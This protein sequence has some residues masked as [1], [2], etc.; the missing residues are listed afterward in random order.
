[1]AEQNQQKSNQNQMTFENF[2]K[3]NLKSYG[4]DLFQVMEKGLSSSVKEMGEKRG[5]TISL[6]A[7]FGNGKT[8]FLKMFEHFIK[9]EKQNYDIILINAWESDF[10][11]EPVITILSELAIWIEQTKS[12][13]VNKQKEPKIKKAISGI[14]SAIGSVFS[15]A[16][17]HKTGVNIKEVKKAYSK[18][19]SASP[20]QDALGENIL[21]D[22]KQ[23]KKAVQK[24]REAILEYIKVSQKK[25][26]IIVDELDRTRPDYAVR[27]LEDIKHFFDIENVVFLVAVNRTQ[28]EVTVKCLYGQDLDFEGYYR[29]FFKQEMELPD[30]YKEA[31]KLVS[32]LIEKTNV[33]YRDN[34]DSRVK[35]TYWS[36]KMFNLTLREIESFIRIFEMVLGH[37]KSIIEWIYMDA[38]SFFICLYLK[39]KEVFKSIK[40][41][42]SVDNFISFIKNDSSLKAFL[43]NK[44]KYYN[45]NRLLGI[46]ACSFLMAKDRQHFLS[47]TQ[48]NR[49]AFKKDKQTIKKYFPTVEGQKFLHPESEVS[50]TRRNDPA[51]SNSVQRAI[52]ICESID[53]C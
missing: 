39:R 51:I 6:N 44:T 9:T 17:Q 48:E 3:L 28:M 24:V 33:K 12:Q 53:K 38:Y 52:S 42:F 29:K 30:P 32:N 41:G 46:A 8:T 1:M 35:N 34:K 21:E 27:F 10:Y 50:S 2:D 37:E 25:L 16:V 20:N 18:Q 13:G 49:E 15:Q 4:E 40:K 7:D 23:R 43:Y 26:L 36:C 31:Q 5:L 22:F 19:D 11:K 47:L 45:E 14:K